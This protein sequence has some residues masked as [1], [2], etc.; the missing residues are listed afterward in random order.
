M[1]PDFLHSRLQ[2]AIAGEAVLDEERPALRGRR[3]YTAHAPDAGRPLRVT[4]H[5]TPPE[6]PSPERLQEKLSRLK[7][8]DHASVILPIAVGEIEGRAWVVDEEPEAVTVAVRLAEQGPQPVRQAVRVVR[9]VAR[10]LVAL[11]RRGLAHGALGLDTVLLVPEGTRIT[12]LALSEGGNASDDLDAL[13]TL[14]RALFY[15]DRPG[16]AS[17]SRRLPPEIAALLE[18]MGSDQPGRRPQKAVAVL[19]VL[20]TF[21]VEQASTLGALIDSAGRGARSRPMH[22]TLGL[23]VLGGVILVI[24]AILASQQ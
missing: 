2:L 10:V 16:S 22:T 15:G 8:L 6:G 13:A 19:G 21:P 20:D 5:P 4:L 9:D 14:A 1:L 18:A 23:L 7:E 11:H 17:S 12:G 3:E 24:L